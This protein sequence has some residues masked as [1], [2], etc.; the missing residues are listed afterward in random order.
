MHAHMSV[1]IYT[2]K[3]CAYP[4][5]LV[6]TYIHACKDIHH[7]WLHTHLST[8]IQHTCMHALKYT[9][10]QTYINTYKLIDVCLHI[11]KKTNI[12]THTCLATYMPKYRLM[13]AC[14]YTFMQTQVHTNLFVSHACLHKSIYNFRN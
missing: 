9:W 4:H 11:C 12:Y 2:S 6:A 13:H 14:L 5:A 8:S 1:Y 10:M 7:V 3:I